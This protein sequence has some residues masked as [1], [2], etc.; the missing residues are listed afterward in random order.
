MCSINHELKAIYIHLPKN[1]GLYIQKILE[2]FYNFKTLY[3]THENHNEFSD[4]NVS[5]IEPE[6]NGFINFKKKGLL[7]Y[8]M[9]SKK[10]NT[11]ANLSEEKWKT[12]YK[13]TFIRNPYDK[14]VSA[15][16]YI[17]SNNYANK[18]IS[19]NQFIEQ[20]DYCSDYTYFHSFI[21]QYQQLLD[22]NNEININYFGKFEN[23]NI[24][25]I[26]IL[27]NIGVKKISHYSVIE[28]NISINRSNIDK[29]YASYY[30]T[31]LLQKVNHIFNEDFEYFNY[32]KNKTVDD[33]ITDSEKYYI[34]NDTLQNKNKRII[35]TVLLQDNGSI[36]DFNLL[37]KNTNGV[38]RQLLLKEI[39]EK[40]DIQKKRE[41]M[42]KHYKYIKDNI[43]NMINLSIIK[44]TNLFGN[45]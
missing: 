22:L 5:D 25:L 36:D 42:L 17:N 12:Y 39:K 31:E 44:Q 40:Q 18:K 11:V 38:D 20:K 45:K 29:N 43:G 7:R 21:S 1:G 41:E 13:F 30:D 33:L 2:D 24:E 32:T 34:S 6:N 3:F 35:D 26:H 27:K 10:Y 4:L 14:L 19:F 23:L 28:K 37:D 15:Y 8:H 9:S 16:K